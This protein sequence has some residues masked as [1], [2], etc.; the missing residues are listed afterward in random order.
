MS[1]RAKLKRMSAPDAERLLNSRSYPEGYGPAGFNSGHTTSSRESSTSSPYM[2]PVEGVYASQMSSPVN[3]EQVIFNNSQRNSPQGMQGHAQQ[4]GN[5]AAP[6]TQESKR[7][8]YGRN[9]LPQPIYAP[10]YNAAV[11]DQRMPN[12][13]HTPRPMPG[14]TPYAMH[15]RP[16]QFAPPPG[17]QYARPYN[18]MAFPPRQVPCQDQSN[19]PLPYFPGRTNDGRQV[20]ME[21]QQH[22]AQQPLQNFP[23][24]PMLPQQQLQQQAYPHA[25]YGG[26][27]TPVNGMHFQ[28]TDGAFFAPNGR[29][30]PAPI[31]NRQTDQNGQDRSV[32]S[33]DGSTQ[34]E[35]MQVSFDQS[36]AALQQA[37]ET[38]TS[39]DQPALDHE[40]AA[41]PNEQTTEQEQV[42]KDAADSS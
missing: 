33:G 6:Q 20:P 30:L 3:R 11:S 13:P 28:R 36:Q 4:N 2:Q 14:L 37:Q 10:P 18:A 24:I 40:Q 34:Q 19:L 42:S 41:D 8:S 35:S 12:G 17:M 1:R 38:E 7:R 39:M 5:F 31:S 25:M 32:E 27:M 29:P 16:M 26:M 15:G 22:G 21:E 9:P 23:Q